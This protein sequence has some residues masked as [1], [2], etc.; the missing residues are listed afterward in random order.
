MQGRPGEGEAD[1]GGS[2]GRIP[3]AD[4]GGRAPLRPEALERKPKRVFVGHWDAGKCAVVETDVIVPPFAADRA[5]PTGERPVGDGDGSS[6]Q[7]AAGKEC[8]GMSELHGGNLVSFAIT[9]TCAGSKFNTNETS[10]KGYTDGEEM[11]KIAE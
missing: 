7:T 6:G 10:I 1:L 5:T 4:I 9:D 3:G 2:Q 8:S 11:L